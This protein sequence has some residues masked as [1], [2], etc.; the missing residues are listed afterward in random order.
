MIK[1]QSSNMEMD[2]NQHTPSS[3]KSEENQM[4]V[5]PVE[6]TPQESIKRN[7]FIKLETTK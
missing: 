1:Q 4:I 6:T 3:K 7:N 5:N 2:T